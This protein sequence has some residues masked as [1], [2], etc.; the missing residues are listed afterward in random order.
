MKIS[1][2]LCTT[3]TACHKRWVAFL[4]RAPRSKVGEL[5]FE[6]D[7]CSPSALADV[8]QGTDLKPCDLN[9]VSVVEDALIYRTRKVT[10]KVVL[11]DCILYIRC[12]AHEDAELPREAIWQDWQYVEP[13]THTETRYRAVRPERVVSEPMEKD[14]AVLSGAWSAMARE[15]GLMKS[16]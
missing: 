14:R 3:N 4:E 5:L 1:D 11:S 12:I 10:Y 9:L 7:G 15:S 2:T 8:V 16:R 13:Y 6:A